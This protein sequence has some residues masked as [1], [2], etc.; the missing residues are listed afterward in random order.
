[1]SAIFVR[2]DS[3]PS[4]YRQC[5]VC[6]KV[7]RKTS[8]SRHRRI[9][10]GEKP[11]ACEICDYR[12]NQKSNLRLHIRQMHSTGDEEVP[13]YVCYIC[14]YRSKVSS[15]L[16]SHIRNTHNLNWPIKDARYTKLDE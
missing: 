10:T 11:F 5:L 14:N 7:I 4:G 8:Y 9:H 2:N 6:L 13:E 3:V 12:S 1:M 15:N 16:S